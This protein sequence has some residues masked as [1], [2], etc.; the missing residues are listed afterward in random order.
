MRAGLAGLKCKLSARAGPLAAIVRRSMRKFLIFAATLALVLMLLDRL[1]PPDRMDTTVHSNTF[2]AASGGEVI[3][4]LPLSG[5]GIESCSVPQ[6]TVRALP[7]KNEVV[8]ATSAIFGRC[9]GV[10]PSVEPQGVDRTVFIDN[11]IRCAY[12]GVYTNLDE[13]RRDYP[14]FAPRIRKWGSHA[15]YLPARTHR[16]SVQLPKE[17]VILEPSGSARAIRACG[18]TEGDCEVVAPTHTKEPRTIVFIAKSPYS[19][20]ATGEFSLWALAIMLPLAWLGHRGA[21]VLESKFHLG[22]ESA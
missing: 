16:Y 7:E 22:R 19:E 14:G 17:L 2:T 5:G 12:H 6:D 3:Y 11:A 4:N 20:R 13:L 1:L 18:A 15:W 21:S 10:Y 9:T 8:V